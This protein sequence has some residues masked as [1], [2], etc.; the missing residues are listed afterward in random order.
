MDGGPVDPFSTY[1]DLIGEL[2]DQL[3]ELAHDR[4]R[5]RAEQIAGEIKAAAAA[6]QAEHAAAIAEWLTDQRR[7][8]ELG[9]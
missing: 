8:E 4:H 5:D 3:L 6:E 9:G 1:A 2:A 7:L